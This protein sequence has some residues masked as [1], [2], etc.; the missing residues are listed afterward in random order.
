MARPD[1]PDTEPTP[2][3]M[4]REIDR[5]ARAQGFDAVGFARPD[6]VAGAGD[7]LARFVALGHHGTMGWMQERLHHRRRPANLWPDVGSV[8]AVGLN[9]GP[10]TDPR[11]LL[12]HGDR[13]VISV[14]ARGKDYHDV[15][16]KRLKALARAIHPLVGPLKVFV[17]TAPVMEK[18]LAAAAGLGW[19]GKH[20][21]LVSTEL[22][23]WLFLGI[24]YLERD[25][26]ADR[27]EGSAGGP[28]HEDRCGSC[29]ACLDVCPT[30][31]FTGPYRIDARR[32]ISYLTI[33]H[34]GP[35]PLEFRAAMGNR[36]YGC[37]DC[38]AV[39]PWN[40]FARR[41]GEAAF[42]AR[43][44][45]AAPKLADL[46]DLDDAAFRQVFSGSPIKRIGRNAFVR[47][48]LIA[49]GNSGDEEFLP[50]AQALS[51]DPDPVVADAAR[52]AVARLKGDMAL[53]EPM[54][55]VE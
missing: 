36:I 9:Y 22:G 12:A 47:N 43:A 42:H 29:R 40:K 48:V 7:D 54:D 28:G 53:Y 33:E 11:A 19:Q 49:I 26:L 18:P 21:N 51:A 3:H 17:D 24:V 27:P 45:L 30:D 35:I 55:A 10:D 37:D 34:R 46:A 6:D 44:E 38:L 14:Y 41:A 32:C 52:W 20:T 16:K 15:V 39:C 23:S 2:A 25:V 5:A 1:S 13:G 50:R 31:A 4:R 8:V